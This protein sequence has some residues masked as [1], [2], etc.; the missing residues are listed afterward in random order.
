MLIYIFKRSSN[1]AVP[2]TCKGWLKIKWERGSF[3]SL[4]LG[5]QPARDLGKWV[6]NFATQEHDKLL[7]NWSFGRTIRFGF[8]SLGHFDVVSYFKPMTWAILWFICLF[9]RKPHQKFHT[10]FWWPSYPWRPY[11]VEIKHT[12]RAALCLYYPNSWCVGSRKHRENFQFHCHRT[13]IFPK[14]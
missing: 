3:R 13:R 1:Y 14:L 9:L 6:K 5:G 12:S 2:S 10:H 8:Y 4:Y 7:N 11:Q